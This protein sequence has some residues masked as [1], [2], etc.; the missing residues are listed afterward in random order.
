VIA[1]LLGPGQVKM[2][3]QGVE[4]GRP[5]SDL[6]LFHCAID[7]EEDFTFRGQRNRSFAM[8][9]FVCRPYYSLCALL[10]C[11]R[12]IQRFAKVDGQDA[13]TQD[14]GSWPIMATSKTA[15]STAFDAFASPKSA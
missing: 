15:A 2:F 9:V 14:V 3:A 11:K 1:S 6:Y 8:S 5:G 10:K 7:L 13:I 12:V 4:Q